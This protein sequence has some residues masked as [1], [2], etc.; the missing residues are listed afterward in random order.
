[1]FSSGRK[2]RS[3]RFT[4]VR[5]EFIELFVIRCNEGRKVKYK[6]NKKIKKITGESNTITPMMSFV[7][8][9]G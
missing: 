5:N 6:T 7:L 9:S 8:S 1:M 3:K 4:D 2:T